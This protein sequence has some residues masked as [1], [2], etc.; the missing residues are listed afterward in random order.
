VRRVR[1]DNTRAGSAVTLTML[2]T[3]IG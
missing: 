1:A 3:I 2:V